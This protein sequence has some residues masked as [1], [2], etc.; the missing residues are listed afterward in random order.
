MKANGKKAQREDLFCFYSFEWYIYFLN[1]NMVCIRCH[2]SPTGMSFRVNI[3]DLMLCAQPASRDRS[4]RAAWEHHPVTETDPRTC[5]H[6]LGPEAVE[7]AAIWDRLSRL[8]LP[9]LI[10]RLVRPCSYWTRR[11]ATSDLRS[12]QVHV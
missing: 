6:K 12:A 10:E 9:L 4:H 3:F 1:I 7:A 2:E 8:G 11:R 5:G